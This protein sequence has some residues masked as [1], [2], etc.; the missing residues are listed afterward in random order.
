MSTWGALV[1]FVKKKD[2]TMRMCIDYRQL[3]KLTINNKYPL[4]RI[5]DLFSQFRGASVFSNIDLCLGY[6]QLRVKEADVHKIAFRTRYGHYE[7]LVVPFGLT[8]APAAFMDLM[9][10]TEDEHDEHLRV[11]LQILREKQLHAK[12]ISFEGIQV[13]PYKIKA[14]LDWKRPKNV[15]EIC[16]FLGLASYYRRFVKGF[17]LIAAPLTKLLH[18]RVPFV[19][20]DAQQESFEKLK[21][22]L[23]QSPVLIQPELGKDF[24]VYSDTLH[25]GL[26]C[27]L[28]QDSKVVAYV[29]RQLKTH[30]VSY[31]THDL[32]LATV[33]CTIKYHLGKANVVADEL[34]RRAM[35]NLRVMFTGLSLLDDES[36]LV[37]LQ[38][39]LTWIEQIR[40]KQLED[41]SL[42]VRF[43][44]VE[45]GGTTDFGVNSDGVLYFCGRICVS[46]N[47]DLR[48]SILREAHSSA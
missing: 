8:N 21:T 42:E 46:N 29:S 22:V 3:N 9:N 4:S 10:R 39:K 35:T 33:D 37:E 15:S 40:G 23:T 20:K 16:S 41:K 25:V 5:D 30:E 14:V 13:D 17:S 34:S 19:W 26:G 2:E 36:L 28:M 6:H 38:V 32:E 45:N 43:R 11:V 44:Q 48:Q 12:F 27:V 1:L 47:E 18:K 7:F 24:V 31:P